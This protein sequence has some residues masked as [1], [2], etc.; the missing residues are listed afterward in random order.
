MTDHAPHTTDRR[1]FIRHNTGG[2]NGWL[3][4]EHGKDTPVDLQVTRQFY[5]A[6]GEL[7]VPHTFDRTAEE[8]KGL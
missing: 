3:S 8:K 1:R 7:L 4:I 5:F 2:M 6:E